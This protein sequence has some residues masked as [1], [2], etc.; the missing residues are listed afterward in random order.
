MKQSKSSNPRTARRR[1]SWR[2]LVGSTLGNIAIVGGALSLT[3]GS[4]GIDASGVVQI[5]DGNLQIATADDGV[6][7]G[8]GN[9]IFG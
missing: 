9:R 3:A 6:H 5:D 7:A 2:W 1:A 4:D 8:I